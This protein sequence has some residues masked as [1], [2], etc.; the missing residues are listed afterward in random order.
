MAFK[1]ILVAVDGSRESDKAIEVIVELAAKLG[2]KVTFLHVVNTP[3]LGDT[4]LLSEKPEKALRDSLVEA[5]KKILA[6]ASETA[7][8]KGVSAT[9]KISYGY[10]SDTIVRE[11]S[12][13]NVDL[14]AMGSRGRTGVTRIVLGSTAEKVLRWSSVPVLIMKDQT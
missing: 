6:K 11:A 3:D 12:S 13:L 10:P 9:E 7:K 14:I 4:S 5:G 2:A 8:R 1:N